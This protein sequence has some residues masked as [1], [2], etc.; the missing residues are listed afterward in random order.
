MK[1]TDQQKQQQQKKM[2]SKILFL[3]FFAA[4]LMIMAIYCDDQGFQPLQEISPKD[5]KFVN[6]IFECI[7]VGI[8]NNRR[9]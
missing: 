8:N 7:F 6:N 9:W 2:Y 1:K 4:S 5:R 3:N